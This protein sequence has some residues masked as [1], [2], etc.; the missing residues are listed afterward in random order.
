MDNI[1]YKKIYEGSDNLVFKIT[2]VLEYYGVDSSLFNSERATRLGLDFEHLV[3]ALETVA[4][5]NV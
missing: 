2:K 3:K 5:E 1:Q 4:R